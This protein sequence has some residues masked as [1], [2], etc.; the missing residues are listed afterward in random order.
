MTTPH[1]DPAL[2]AGRRILLV[3]DD[4]LLANALGSLLCDRGVQLL[5]PCGTVDDALRLLRSSDALDAVVLDGNLD[6]ERAD[7]VAD[8]VLARGIPLVFVSG[9]DRELLPPRFKDV[10]HCLKPVDVDHLAAAL[11]GQL[12][13]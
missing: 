9:Y 4:Y 12:E 6:G 7:R 11:A 1:P 3:E 5:G 10:P 2:L 13:A 8:A